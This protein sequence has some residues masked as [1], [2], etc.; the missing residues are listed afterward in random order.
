[1]PPELRAIYPDPQDRHEH[2]SNSIHLSD[3]ALTVFLAELAKRPQ[4]KDSLVII[5][6]DHSFPTGEHGYTNNV[7]SFY[8][9]FFR[10]PMLLLWPGHIEPHR[11]S[12]VP[13]SQID[14]APTIVDLLGF[15]EVKH[16]FLGHSLLDA[17]AP[18]PIFLVQP[19]SGRYLGVVVAPYKFV[20]HERTGEE[21]LFNL[22]LDPKEQQN[23]V[24]DA[25]QQSRVGEMRPLLKQIAINEQLLVQDQIWP[26]SN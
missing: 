2:Y 10:T 26:R 25:D 5:T 24:G 12:D 16:H 14:I 20:V 8:E 3:A 9:E 11:I 23:L 18:R 19:Y 13:R 21:F 17:E 6:G 7:S 4:F 1:V 22:Q 15:S